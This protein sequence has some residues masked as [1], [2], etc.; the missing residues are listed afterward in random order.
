MLT[1]QNAKA[2]AFVDAW[3]ALSEQALVPNPFFDPDFCLPAIKRLDEERVKLAVI[4][5]GDGSII[6]LAPFVLA[7]FARFGPKVA[8]IWAHDYLPLSTPLVRHDCAGALEELL[9]GISTH[10][11]APVLVPL[12]KGLEAFAPLSSSFQMDV[13]STHERAAMESTLS[14]EEYRRQTLSKQRRQGLNRRYRR[15]AERTAHLGDLHIELCNDAEQVP[16][17]FETF[18]RVEKLGWKGGNKT[19]LLN[20]EDHAALGRE[21]AF[22]FSQRGACYI[23]TLRA[24]DTVLAALTLFKAKDTLFSWKTSFDETYAECSPGSQ[25]LSRFADPLMGLGEAVMLDSCAAPDNTLANA[26]W[27]ERVEVQNVLFMPP[28]Y[29]T[30]G[31]AIRNFLM[32]HN[33]ARRTAKRLIRGS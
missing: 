28:A 4:M 1:F 3:R 32:L 31:T 13:L 19:A 10:S 27:G 20:V 25:I 24:G 8:E 6:A 30:A 12:M 33:Q 22:G 9:I 18:M 17:R 5:D 2:E 7:R 21:A 26:I 29:K 23:A 14:G 15:L 11:N 16:S